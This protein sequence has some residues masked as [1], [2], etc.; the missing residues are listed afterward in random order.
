VLRLSAGAWDACVVPEQGGA[1][2]RLDHAKRSVLRPAP[3]GATDPFAYAC[4]ALIP[5]ANRIADGRLECG[6]DEYR[7][8]PNHAGQRHPLH[9]IGWLAPWSVTAFD[10]VG[11]TMELRHGGDGA[12]PWSFSATQMLLLS[13]AG[14]RAVLTLRNDSDRTMPYSLGFH[15]Y[16]ATSPDDRLTFAAGGVWLANEEMLPI[17]HAAHDALGDWSN[18]APLASG[19]LIDNCYTGWSGHAKIMRGDTAIVLEGGNTPNLH[20]YRPPHEDFICLEPVTAIP[21]AL[22]RISDQAL[23]PG[24]RAEITMR[25]SIGRS[26]RDPAQ[27]RAVGRRRGTASDWR[28]ISV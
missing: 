21:D 13:A 3:E 15:P 22:S 28:R 4:F 7:L 5:Y 19:A 23:A 6:G 1:I 20:L 27:S 14:I 18:L 24:G 10:H 17:A 26:V 25:I 2:A 16:F 9:G 11:L 12:W 8:P